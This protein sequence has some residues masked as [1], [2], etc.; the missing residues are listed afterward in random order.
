MTFLD[1]MALG[2]LHDC[3]RCS[4]FLGLFTVNLMMNSNLPCIAQTAR[5]VGTSFWRHEL[6]DRMSNSQ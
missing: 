5:G 2:G 4:L 1:C 6:W 3:A